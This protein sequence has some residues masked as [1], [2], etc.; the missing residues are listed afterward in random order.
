MG[1]IMGTAAYMSPEQAAGETA[2]RRSDIWSFGVVLFEM[3]TGQ[4]LFTGKTVSHV[5]ASTGSQSQT[6]IR[7]LNQLEAEPLS[8]TEGTFPESFS[9]DGQWLLITEFA[10]APQVLKRVPLAGG[11]PITVA[12][13]P[14]R[15]LKKSVKWD[16]QIDL[17]VL[18]CSQHF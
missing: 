2:D 5:L 11:R 6:Y 10:T 17:V 18:R 9:P 3:L 8:G 12:E 16:R 14:S 1:V 4:R 15:L 13:W 7:N